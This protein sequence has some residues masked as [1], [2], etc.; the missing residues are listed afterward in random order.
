VIYFVQLVPPEGFRT[1]QDRATR[2]EPSVQ[3][4]VGDILYSN[5]TNHSI[6]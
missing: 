5:N 6:S 4:F 2:W 1:S 3:H